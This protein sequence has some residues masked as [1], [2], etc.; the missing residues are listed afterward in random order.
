MADT[1]VWIPPGRWVDYFTGATFTGPLTTTLA[2]PLDRMPV[3]VRAGGII[4]EQS[5][6]TTATTTSPTHLVLKV[7]S[8]SS[9]TFSLYGDSGSGLGYTL[10][11]YT[12]TRI[13]DATRSAGAGPGVARVTVAATT[14]HYR[15]QPTAVGYRLD[16][17]DLSDPALVTLNGR[18]LDRQTPGSARTGWYYQSSTATVVVTTASRPTTEAFTVVATGTRTVSRPEPSPASS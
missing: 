9:A 16:L 6:S 1:T 8:G 12:E 5:S 11:Q 7:F 18:R 2:V 14:G 17:V 13:T 15:G 4:P 3:F 10:G